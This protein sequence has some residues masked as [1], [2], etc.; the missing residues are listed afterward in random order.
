MRVC[1]GDVSAGAA[2]AEDIF[3]VHSVRSVRVR[4][5]AF[6]FC[7]A[8]VSIICTKALFMLSVVLFLYTLLPVG[9][10]VWI[11]SVTNDV[12]QLLE[13]IGYDNI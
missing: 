11:A 7:C 3:G 2:G 1:G 13:E 9:S 10:I 6:T 4:A 8:V 5:A 12:I